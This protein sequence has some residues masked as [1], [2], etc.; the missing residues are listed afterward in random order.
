MRTWPSISFLPGI[1]S[2]V[3]QDVPYRLLISSRPS[4]FSPGY[5]PSGITVPT[6]RTT[7]YPELVYFFVQFPLFSVSR[8]SRP[9]LSMFTPLPFLLLETLQLNLP[10]I[11]TFTHQKLFLIYPYNIL[12]VIHLTCIYLRFFWI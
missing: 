7:Q 4:D 8:G 1:S 10:Y 5:V 3:A 12:S 11:T 9:L 2:L 6:L